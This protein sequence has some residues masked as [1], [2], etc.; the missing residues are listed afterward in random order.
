M[1]VIPGWLRPGRPTA[2]TQVGSPRLSISISC[3]GSLHGLPAS[4]LQRPMSQS[5]ESKA[6]TGSL[7]SR[8]H[9]RP[10]TAPSTPVGSG[11]LTL[12]AHLAGRSEDAGPMVGGGP[13]RPRARGRTPLLH[14]WAAPAC[15]THGPFPSFAFV[16]RRQTQ[17]VPLISGDVGLA[18]R[19][20]ALWKVLTVAQA[21]VVCGAGTVFLAAPHGFFPVTSGPRGSL[22]SCLSSALCFHVS[23]CA[24]SGYLSLSDFVFSAPGPSVLLGALLRSLLL[25]SVT[26]SLDPPTPQLG[27]LGLLQLE[28]LHRG[29]G[30]LH[31]P[32]HPP[33][34]M[35]AASW[36]LVAEGEPPAPAEQGQRSGRQRPPR[37]R[38]PCLG[39]PQRSLS[40]SKRG[41]WPVVC[42]GKLG[43][44]LSTWWEV[45][46]R[47]VNGP[48]SNPGL[49]RELRPGHPAAG[50]RGRRKA[51]GQEASKSVLLNVRE[52]DTTS[53][54][55]SRPGG[56]E[57]TQ[58]GGIPHVL[59]EVDVEHQEL[60]S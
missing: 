17:D 25:G 6:K 4:S 16:E 38:D 52:P 10:T 21:P 3:Q 31:S 34:P 42:S 37:P 48:V 53:S 49:Q 27:V 57:N 9:T 55:G 26:G 15:S 54:L 14:S 35:A 32:L 24:Q 11:R 44:A 60:R 33:G 47:A 2:H 28:A 43:S 29:P 23:L 8:C 58:E 45:R 46:A 30:S 41:Q 1:S 18:Q 59:H 51:D 39:R 7:T 19:P 13:A 40:F 36:G 50:S 12:L 20:R 22:H 56:T 5:S